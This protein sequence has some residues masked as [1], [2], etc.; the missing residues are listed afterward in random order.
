MS[1]PIRREL[2]KFGED[3]FQLV[4]SAAKVDATDNDRQCLSLTENNRE[5]LNVFEMQ[6]LG[7]FA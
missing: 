6:L 4:V 7:M 5:Y 2:V 3:I 1:S